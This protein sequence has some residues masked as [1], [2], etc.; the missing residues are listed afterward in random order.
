MQKNPLP[1]SVP[2]ICLLGRMEA[3][4][5]KNGQCGV[6]VELYNMFKGE[7][8]S[9]G[10]ILLLELVS[11]CVKSVQIRSFFCSVFSS[12]RTEYGPEKTSY[13]DTFHA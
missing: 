5:Y 4:V 2:L 12:I 9:G 7:T 11:H 3:H 6:G 1:S 8:F 10:Y 13:L